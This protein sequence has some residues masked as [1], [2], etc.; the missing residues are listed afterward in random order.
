L[1]R[2]PVVGLVFLGGTL[3][4]LS[5]FYTKYAGSARHHGFLFA[6]FVVSAWMYRS[7][8]TTESGAVV[9]DVRH[10]RWQKAFA[11]SLTLLFGVHAVCRRYR[12]DLGV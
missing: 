8:T 5:F 6:C 7:D 11:A 10:Q 4:L 3:G 9:N 2:N 1:R 12:F